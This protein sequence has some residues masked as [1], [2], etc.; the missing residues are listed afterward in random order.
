MGDVVR[1]CGRGIISVDVYSW[2]RVLPRWS[3]AAERAAAAMPCPGGGRRSPRARSGREP[4][5]AHDLAPRFDLASFEL[6]DLRFQTFGTA[7][8][9]TLRRSLVGVAG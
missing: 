1:R 3:G 4:E 6:G 2:P 7:D 9:W 8:E 5:G